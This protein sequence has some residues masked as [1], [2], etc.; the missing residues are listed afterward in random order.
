MTTWAE[1]MYYFFQMYFWMENM[2][3]SAV[4]YYSKETIN[5]TEQTCLQIVLKT[6]AEKVSFA[7]KISS[8]ELFSQNN[9]A[10]THDK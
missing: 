5:E 8:M 3:K 6:L 4:D 1:F 10:Y 7:F 9:L 2:K